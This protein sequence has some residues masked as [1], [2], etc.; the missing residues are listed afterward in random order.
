MG[1]ELTLIGVIDDSGYELENRVYSRGGQS[2]TL[3]AGNA[4]IRT[5]R[6]YE[7]DNRTRCDRKNRTAES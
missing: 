7:K 2:P 3:K 5:V 6:R 1:K 4:K